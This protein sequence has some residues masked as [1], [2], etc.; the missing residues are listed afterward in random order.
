MT[1]SATWFISDLHLDAKR[2]EMVQAFMQFLGTVPGQAD[3]LYILGDLFEYWIGDDIVESPAGQ[4]VIPLLSG[5][6]QVSEAGVKLYFTHGN[7]DFLIGERFTEMTGCEILAEKHVIDLHG[8]PTLLMHGDT[9]CTDDVEYQELRTM[10]YDPAQ[11]QR[12][13][14]LDFE[15]RVAEANHLR[16]MSGEKMQEKAQEIMDVN[17]QAVEQAMT[18]SGVTQLIHGHTHRPNIHNF[19]L[20]DRP[21]KRVVLGDWYEQVSCLKVGDGQLTLSE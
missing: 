5:L 20:N 6:K 17:Q 1:Q 21:A 15:A 18:E 12:F 13:L 16:K 2:P 3:S 10:F 9:L 19:I 4:L 8:T 7:R 14:A 11:R